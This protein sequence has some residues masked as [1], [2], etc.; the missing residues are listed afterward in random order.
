MTGYYR[1]EKGFHPKGP[2]TGYRA[3]RQKGRHG[4]RRTADDEVYEPT[5]RVAHA[6][7][8]NLHAA[9]ANTLNGNHSSASRQVVLGIP[10]TV[11]AAEILRKSVPPEPITLRFGH[12][13]PIRALAFSPDGKRLASASE[14]LI[15][16]WDTSSGNEL[17]TLL[18]QSENFVT[19]VWSNDGA[20]LL[21]IE[22]DKAKVWDSYSGVELT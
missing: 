15:K 21:S 20:H 2:S 6:E 19:L 8:N 12:T 3:F 7:D 22:G 11:E 5:D 18:N 14:N 13:G 1:F 16:I 17:L 9:F 4:C 10:K